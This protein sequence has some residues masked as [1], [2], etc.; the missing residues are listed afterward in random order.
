MTI[1]VAK[2]IY[3]MKDGAGFGKEGCDLKDGLGLGK[4]G[5]D[6]QKVSK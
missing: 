3:G 6:G 1:L 4:E 5:W 2:E